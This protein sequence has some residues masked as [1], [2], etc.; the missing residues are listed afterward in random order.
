MKSFVAIVS[1][2]SRAGEVCEVLCKQSTKVIKT[3]QELYKVRNI[4]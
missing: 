4:I 3:K 1:M 2:S